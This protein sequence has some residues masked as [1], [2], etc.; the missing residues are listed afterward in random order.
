LAELDE[1]PAQR[2]D[3]A[4]AGN[5]VA[6]N[7]PSTMKVQWHEADPDPPPTVNPVRV[8]HVR[9][10]DGRMLKVVK[11]ADNPEYLDIYVDVL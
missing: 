7:A 6:M 5:E 9:A 1:T 3:E 10:L 2:L 8:I 4:S 11:T